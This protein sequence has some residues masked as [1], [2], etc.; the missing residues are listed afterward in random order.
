[1][2]NRVKDHSMHN[3]QTNTQK[4]SSHKDEDLNPM[5]GELTACNPYCNTYSSLYTPQS[6]QSPELYLDLSIVFKT[7]LLNIQ[8]TAPGLSH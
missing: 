7:K 6:I 2:D 5:E 1:M 4:S 8:H 3:F